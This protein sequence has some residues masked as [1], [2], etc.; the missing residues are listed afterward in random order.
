MA[1]SSFGPAAG[2]SFTGFNTQGF[3]KLGHD[4]YLL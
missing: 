3:V 4:N 2:V 1:R